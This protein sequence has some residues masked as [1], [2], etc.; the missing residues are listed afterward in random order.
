MLVPVFALTA[1]ATA[2]Q[3]ACPTYAAPQPQRPFLWKVSGPHGSIVLYATHQAAAPEDVPAA[4]WA[5]LE[6]AQVYVT[7]A[8]DIPGSMNTRDRSEWNEAFY[9]PRGSSL[10]KMLAD[11]D[12]LELRRR[13]DGPVNHYKPWV[14]MLK[15]AA[16]AYH[17]PSTSMTTGIQERARAR[18]M[19]I[20]F[21]ET[22]T[23]QV[24]YLDAAVTPAKLSGMIRDYPRLGC[25]LANRL[26][27]FRAGD[28][29]V[30]A[31]EIASAEEPVVA[32][33]GRWFVRL[34]E[35]VVA[36]R[37]AFVAIGIGQIV[38]PYGLLA[39]FAERG[40]E[41]KRL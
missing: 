32:R 5:E 26:V 37:R 15:L 22:W 19:P 33:I 35:Y 7:E 28:D 6:H 38:G 18:G 3:P 31:N 17:F 40:Y 39:K 21:L 27:A 2:P 1:C 9:L 8:E 4:A 24:A 13:L 25:T 11:D 23:E 41:V 14:A 34:D 29:A 20:E 10:M 36:G 12:Y 16:S 30:F